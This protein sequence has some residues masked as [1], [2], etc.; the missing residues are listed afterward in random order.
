MTTK[1]LITGGKG[2]LASAIE[3]FYLKLNETVLAP[4]HVELDVL[5]IVATKE[6]FE[7]FKPDLVFHTAALHVDACEENPELAF[8]LNSWASGNLARLCSKYNA[9][10]IYISSCGYFGDEIKYYS[11][12]DQTVL[13]T[14][15]AHSKY[16]GEISALQECKKTFA[17]RP[18]WLFGGEPQ[19][20]KNFVYQ[21]ILE[22]S[23]SKVVKSAVD[24]YGSPT[25][26]N[27]LT[28]KIN[29][30]L[31]TEQPG[32]Y[33]VSNSG[34]CSRFEYVKKIAKSCNLD[35][36]VTPVA[37]DSFPRKANI[38]DCELLNNWNLKFL[39]LN[40]LPPWEEAIERYVKKI[41]K[42]C[43]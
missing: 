34:G 6:T 20:K 1:I 3:E 4:T 7:N 24:K 32:L 29:D 9:T 38:P 23:K 12:Y 40:L 15:Y 2:M 25:Y 33:H 16:Q 35:T 28:D 19:H 22:L 30:I 21:R 13:K 43:P 36:E 11:E 42:I 8:R 31:R 5:D 27:D 18:G 14:I 26:I 17:I 41:K 39:G 37:S 10:L